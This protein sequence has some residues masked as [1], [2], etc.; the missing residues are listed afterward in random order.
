LVVNHRDLGP[1]GETGLIIG[2][3]QMTAPALVIWGL[4]P[5]LINVSDRQ[6]G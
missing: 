3:R 5:L 1:G 2:R 6:S 4:S